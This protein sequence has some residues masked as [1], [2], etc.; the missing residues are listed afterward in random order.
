MYHGQVQGA[1]AR[2]HGDLSVRGSAFAIRSTGF[3]GMSLLGYE[4]EE[5]AGVLRGVLALGGLCKS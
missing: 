1:V 4:E 2:T 3:S 5:G